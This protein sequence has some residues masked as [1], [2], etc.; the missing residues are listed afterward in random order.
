M[1]VIH[2]QSPELIQIHIPDIGWIL[3]PILAT[4]GGAWVYNSDL[5]SLFTPALLSRLALVLGGWTPLWYTVVHTNWAVPLSLWKNWSESD[6]LPP[7]PYLQ[8]ATAGTVLRQRLGQARAWWRKVGKPQ[9]AVPLQFTF[10]AVFASIFLSY[11]IERTV[12]LLTMLFLAS[13]QLAVLWKSSPEK[14]VSTGWLSVTQVGLPWLLGSCINQEIQNDAIMSTFILIVLVGFYTL[15]S[16][17]AITGPL[18]TAAF[19]VWQ[20]HAITAGWLL[21]LSLPGF[22]KLS[23]G[24]TDKAYR[25][26]AL[27]WILGM[28]GLI[29]WVI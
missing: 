27:P 15:N 13:S 16:P 26:A 29:A 23:Q 28:V 22:L 2:D 17:F 19:L 4:I 18:L 1:D 14:E 12:L 6:P 21:L 5:E 20:G 11:T 10:L 7:W 9:L 24:P 3:L 25:N 8:S